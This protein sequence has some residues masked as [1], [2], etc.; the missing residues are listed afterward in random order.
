MRQ[1]ML[2]GRGGARGA[3]GGRRPTRHGSAWLVSVAEWQRKPHVWERGGW[4][5]RRA[6]TRELRGRPSLGC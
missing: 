3:E 1:M 5:E 6:R 4:R 2:E